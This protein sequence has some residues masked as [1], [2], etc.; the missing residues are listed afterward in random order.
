[1]IRRPPRSTLFPYTTLFRSDAKCGKEEGTVELTWMSATEIN[2]DF[3]TIA[4]C[5]D[6]HNFEVIATINGAGNSSNVNSYYFKDAEAPS[7]KLYYRLKQ[8]DF[9]GN[10]E[11][12]DIKAVDCGVN[13]AGISIYPNPTVNN[14]VLN[15]NGYNEEKVQLEMYNAIGQKV[16]NKIFIIKNNDLNQSI[17]VDYLDEGIYFINI[18]VGGKIETQK[19]VIE[20]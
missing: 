13:A 10:F 5:T 3:Y 17:V 20:R 2:N 4:R 7:G 19:L 6:T 12:F 8:T 15:V 18:K 16:I 9:N 11:Y 14:F 1:M